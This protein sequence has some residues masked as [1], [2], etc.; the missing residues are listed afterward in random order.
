[1]Y[2]CYIHTHIYVYISQSPRDWDSE[3][4]GG[5]KELCVCQY[6]GDYEGQ[7]IKYGNLVQSPNLDMEL[8]LESIVSEGIK[9][10]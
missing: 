5:A 8:L 3:V 6:L 2:I 7:R 4:L 10:P 9:V 1:M